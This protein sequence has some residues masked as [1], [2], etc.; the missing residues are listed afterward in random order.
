MA[1]AAHADEHLDHT[2][3]ENGRRGQYLADAVLGATDGIV[4]TFAVVT[5]AAGAS[6]STGVVLIMGFANLAADGFSMAAGN[7]LGGRSQQEYWK[8]EKRREIWEIENLPQAEKEEIRRLYRQ[9]GFEGEMLEAVVHTITADKRIWLD[10]MM[11]EELGIQEEG[12]APLR[13]GLVT[14]AAFTIAGLLPLIFYVWAFFQPSLAQSALPASV[15]LTAV[16]L[17]T[18]GAARRFMMR[19]SWW[20]SGLEILLV[21]GLAATCAFVLGR[22]LRSLV[23]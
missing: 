1:H 9:K 7:Y 15:G 14:F 18:V 8:A 21:G 19:T 5:G 4:T 13:S 22:A 2:L 3:R 10:E 6:L 23:G 11:R 16:A 17:F 12:V 20:R